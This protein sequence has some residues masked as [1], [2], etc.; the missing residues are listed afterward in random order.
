MGTAEQA[1]RLRVARIAAKMSLQVV[2]EDPETALAIVMTA[3]QLVGKS[4]GLER[5]DVVDLAREA[6]EAEIMEDSDVVQ[7]Q[8]AEGRVWS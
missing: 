1:E 5:K 6:M 7:A 3:L 4:C 2:S 8:A